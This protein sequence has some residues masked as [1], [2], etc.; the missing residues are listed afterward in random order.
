MLGVPKELIEHALDVH[1]KA[2]P[3]KQRLRRFA[4]D[5]REA[6]KWE[7]AKL[8][9]A[10]FIKEVIHPEWVANPVLVKKKNNEWRMCVDYTDLNKHCPKDHFGCRALTKLSI[11]RLVVSF[12]VFLI[13]TQVIIRSLSRRRTKSRLRS[14]PRT[15]LMPTKP[16]PSG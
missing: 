11:Q 2:T 9:A 8:L 14:S 15:G 1:P 5:K 4:H 13:V 16:Y 3:K 12:S 10:R 7:I 6:I